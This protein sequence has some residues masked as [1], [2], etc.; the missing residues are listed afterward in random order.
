MITLIVGFYIHYNHL[1]NLAE[2]GKQDQIIIEQTTV[3]LASDNEA[4]T[5]YNHD[6]ATID[7]ES[8]NLKIK[9]LNEKNAH[10]LIPDEWLHQLQ[11]ATH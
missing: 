11:A 8:D 7:N 9:Y 4:D 10:A 6:I 5:E 3:K 2:V 1:T